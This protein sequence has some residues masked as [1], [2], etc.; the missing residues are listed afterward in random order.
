MSCCWTGL[1][2]VNSNWVGWV[3][4]GG[5][6]VQGRVAGQVFGLTVLNSEYN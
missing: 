2:W 1:P 3:G 5:G 6:G 4:G